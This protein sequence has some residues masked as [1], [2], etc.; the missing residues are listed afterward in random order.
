MSVQVMCIF[1]LGKELHVFV[2]L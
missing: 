1:V 2:L